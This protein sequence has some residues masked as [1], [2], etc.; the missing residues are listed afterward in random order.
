MS[1]VVELIKRARNEKRLALT[2]AE[3][4]KLLS[5]YGIPVVEETVEAVGKAR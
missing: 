4:K 2:E 3:S 5:A 1:G